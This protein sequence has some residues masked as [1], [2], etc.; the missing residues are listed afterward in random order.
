MDSYLQL[1][2]SFLFF[3]LVAVVLTYTLGLPGG[4]LGCLLVSLHNVLAANLIASQDREG[5]II[6]FFQNL[7]VTLPILFFTEHIFTW[8]KTG[9]FNLII[10]SLWLLTAWVVGYAVINWHTVTHFSFRE[11]WK[12]KNQYRLYKKQRRKE[13]RSKK[14]KQAELESL[15]SS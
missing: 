10:L 6:I 2:I 5:K 14:I 12:E 13:I 1:F 8:V 4:F 15:Y 7:L 9:E 11:Y 3:V